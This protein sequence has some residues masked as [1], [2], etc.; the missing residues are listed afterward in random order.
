[1]CRPVRHPLSRSVPARR[2]RRGD[3]GNSARPV[4]RT[5]T[6]SAKEMEEIYREICD[7]LGNALALLEQVAVDA[8]AEAGLSLRDIDTIVTNTITGLAIPT[9]EA[10]LMNRL[11]FR[12]HVQ[13]LPIFGFGC[14]GGVAGLSG[15]AHGASPAGFQRAV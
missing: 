15:A 1:M 2:T 13:R 7:E 14:G 12:P 6:I 4:G 3:F 11:A 5:G 10:R 9:L 8:V